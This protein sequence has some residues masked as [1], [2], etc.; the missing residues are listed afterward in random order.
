[1]LLAP[2]SGEGFPVTM[3]SR[4][5]PFRGWTRVR[6]T[7]Q[8]RA[9]RPQSSHRLVQRLHEHV[10]A[11][12]EKGRPKLS[13][14]A[15]LLVQNFGCVQ[16]GLRYERATSMDPRSVRARTLLRYYERVS[17]EGLTWA[18]P[19]QLP[20]SG[21]YPPQTRLDASMGDSGSRSCIPAAGERLTLS[22]PIGMFYGAPRFSPDGTQIAAVAFQG[23]SSRGFR[24][25]NLCGDVVAMFDKGDSPQTDVV[26]SRDGTKLF[27]RT[28]AGIFSVETDGNGTPVSVAANGQTMDIS[29]SGTTLTFSKSGDL[30]SLDLSVP[31]ATP[32][33]LSVTGAFP[34][35]SPNGMF[36][37]F[38]RASNL[39]V[40]TLSSGSEPNSI[41]IGT[42]SSQPFDWFPDNQRFA[43]ATSSGIEVFRSDGSSRSVARAETAAMDVDVSG[44]GTMIAYRINGE[45]AIYLLGTPSRLS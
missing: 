16:H 14:P 43:A 42:A 11:A 33:D 19:W 9:P 20:K 39:V 41:A 26:W 40:R 21:R 28:S 6:Q 38:L 2:V 15:V 8:L 3:L 12:R 37:G 24:I 45:R 7:R 34:R 22:P 5:V 10:V 36:L 25:L 17:C 27:Y 13:Q 1:M 32:I 23:L 4:A 30:F 44:D 29:P 31:S 35:Y 18:I